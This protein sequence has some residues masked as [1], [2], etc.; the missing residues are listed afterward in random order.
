[1]AKLKCSKCE[2]EKGWFTQFFQCT[3][4]QCAKPLC[5][6][7]VGLSGGFITTGNILGAL[8]GG[9][10]GFKQGEIITTASCPHCNS[11]VKY[12]G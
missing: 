5:T 7:C 11:P 2:S 9:G 6:K 1:M 4:P 3:N 12:L 10:A 8:S